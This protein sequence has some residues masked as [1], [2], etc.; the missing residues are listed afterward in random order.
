MEFIAFLSNEDISPTRA[1][2]L[3]ICCCI[4]RWLEQRLAHGGGPGESE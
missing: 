4:P 2:I 1:R 3:S